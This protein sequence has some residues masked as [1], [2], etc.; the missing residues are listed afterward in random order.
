MAGPNFYA[1]PY[2]FQCLHG[3]GEPLYRQIVDSAAPCRIYA[4]VGSH[5][6]LLAYLVRRLLENGA[7]TSFVNRIAD[8]NVP[9]EALIEDPVAATRANQPLGSPHPR[10]ALPRELFG[11]A[12]ANSRGRGSQQRSASRALGE[13]L[14]ASA[15]PRPLRRPRAGASAR[16]AIP[17][18]SAT[19]SAKSPTP[20]RRRSRRR[21]RAPAPAARRPGRERPPPKRARILA[22][23]AD[24]FEADA[25][26]SPG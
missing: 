14:V 5:E 8:P 12:R 2:E 11:A 13:A 4:P 22:R 9:V 1:G 19:S 25:G 26:G 3:M 17:P 7:N 18:T 10:I 24:L 16:S 21:L 15:A 20:T 23:A 6:T